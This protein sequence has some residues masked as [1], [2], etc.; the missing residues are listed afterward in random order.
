MDY[1]E[2]EMK[3]IK[4]IPAAELDGL[5]P[6]ISAGCDRYDSGAVAYFLISVFSRIVPATVRTE[7]TSVS[8]VMGSL[9]IKL[10]IQS[11]DYYLGLD[12]AQS[13]TRTYHHVEID[14]FI[15]GYNLPTGQ[16]MKLDMD[17]TSTGLM[18]FNL[19]G[20]DESTAE[21]VTV[22]AEKCFKKVNGTDTAC[23]E[24]EKHV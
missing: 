16:S 7:V 17:L 12:Y 1:I 18:R 19:Y 5:T 4:A 23:S 24:T 14:R 11:G 6:A 2:L 13:I 8:D 21:Y 15:T 9:D 10:H 3:G 20:I 22:L